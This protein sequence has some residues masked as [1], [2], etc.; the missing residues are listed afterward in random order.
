MNNKDKKSLYIILTNSM[1]NDFLERLDNVKKE[2]PENSEIKL[3]YQ[4]VR[5]DWNDYF[6]KLK[7]NSGS[8]IKKDRFKN[9]LD[10]LIKKINNKTNS[11][12]M[13]SS[14]SSISSDS[15]INFSYHYIIDYYRHMVHI[16]D[17]ECQRIWDNKGKLEQ[18]IEDLKIK[19]AR[20]NNQKESSDQ[21]YFIHIRDWHDPLNPSQYL[22][23]Q[24]FGFHCIKG[25]HGA[26]FVKPIKDLINPKT[27][28]TKA[29]NSNN[30]HNELL[31][32]KQLEQY[33]IIIN[34]NSLSCFAGTDLNEVLRAI[35][36]N[37][38]QFYENIEIGIM[39]VITNIKVM[40]LAYELKEIYNYKNITVCEDLCAGF[41]NEKHNEGLDYI[42]QVLGI[43][44]ISLEDFKLK[45]KF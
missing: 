42:E 32:L 31:A 11:N 29:S 28:N 23:F 8:Q 13:D 45:F 36:K 38:T 44:H 12:I 6:K 33:N 35:I 25:S 22:E 16:D 5:K 19:A 39:G 10:N 9:G 41:Y 20:S 43:D 7:N 1:Q 18:T 21:Y 4:E 24:N 30:L 37:E 40:L 26:D 15:S 3:S 34:S 17:S 2:Y 27:P 14:E